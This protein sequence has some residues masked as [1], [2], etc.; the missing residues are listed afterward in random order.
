PVVDRAHSH[1]DLPTI[2][3]E[4]PEPDEPHVPDE[5]TDPDEPTTPENP[6]EP[7]EPKQPD[8]P[9]T[10]DEPNTDLTETK[11]GGNGVAVALF[12]ILV[13]LALGGVGGFIIYKKV[14]AKKQK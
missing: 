8:V 9:T 11:E 10:P 1:P 2:P 5:P 6:D 3:D 14:K 4:P 13:V 7:T 12:V